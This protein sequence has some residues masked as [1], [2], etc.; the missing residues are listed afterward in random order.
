V[1]HFHIISQIIPAIAGYQSDPDYQDGSLFLPALNEKGRASQALTARAL[2]LA[3]IDIANVIRLGG[4]P[5]E[6]GEL[7]YSSYLSRSCPRAWCKNLLRHYA[8]R[9]IW[10]GCQSAMAGRLT[11][12]SSLRAAMVSRV[13]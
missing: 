13:M 12:A 4:D 7:V 8:P 6:V 2:E 3:R 9:R 10:L 5:I 1:N 11:V